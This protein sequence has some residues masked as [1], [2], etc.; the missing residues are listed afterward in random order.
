MDHGRNAD[1][2]ASRLRDIW[3]LL[4]TAEQT[5]GT[6]HHRGCLF[7]AQEKHGIQIL[8]ERCRSATTSPLRIRQATVWVW[9]LPKDSYRR[10]GHLGPFPITISA[11]ESS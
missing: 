10:F 9:Y 6:R 8:M 4:M 1:Y 2:A 11:F 5:L 7:L 3:Q